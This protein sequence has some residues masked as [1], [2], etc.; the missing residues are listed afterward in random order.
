MR[1]KRQL[2]SAF[3]A[4]L[5]LTAG[6]GYAHVAAAS[7]GM[8][9]AP[10]SAAQ[11]RQLV[12][13][14]AG[15]V[16]QRW[17]LDIN[18]D[19]YQVITEPGDILIVPKG[20]PAPKHVEINGVDMLAS[21][22]TVPHRDKSDASVLDDGT[23]WNR[24]MCFARKNVPSKLDPNKIDAWADYCAQ[25][26]EIKYPNQ[27]GTDYAVKEWQTCATTNADGLAYDLTAC[28]AGIAPPPGEQLLD[29]DDWSPKGTINQSPC[30]N[31][32][33]SVSVAGIGGS[34]VLGNFC[35]TLNPV[36]GEKPL[37]FL[38]NWSG[39]APNGQSRDTGGIV[40][41]HNTLTSGI[42]IQ[43]L[44]GGISISL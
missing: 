21:S 38:T 11:Q 44:Y 42:G 10:M 36:K 18:P 15:N 23:V 28:N 26:G 27:N 37:D 12:G 35:D 25:A 3:F 24:P 40:A 14:L 13:Q 43:A 4:S 31:L 7:D 29:W 8:Q 30:T 32:T 16:R 34:L 9:A 2:F 5:M 41:V 1:K 39:N 22:L 17:N 19:D 33:L 6:L 20:L